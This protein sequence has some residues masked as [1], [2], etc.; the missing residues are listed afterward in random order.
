[1]V[2]IREIAAEMV[3]VSSGVEI[4]IRFPVTIRASL[5]TVDLFE[6]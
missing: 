2:N 4:L 6:I 1:M 3:K 5:S